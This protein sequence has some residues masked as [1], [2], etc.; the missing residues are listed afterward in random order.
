MFKKVSL[1]S[2][3]LI[4]IS[5]INWPDY[6]H[7]KPRGGRRVFVSLLRLFETSVTLRETASFNRTRAAGGP[8]R[9]P[10]GRAP[11]GGLPGP[12]ARQRGTARLYAAAVRSGAGPFLSD[13]SPSP[14]PAAPFTPNAEAPLHKTPALSGGPPEHTPGS[15]RVPHS[16]CAPLPRPTRSSAARSPAGP[17]TS[18]R[19]RRPKHP[20]GRRQPSY[21]RRRH[22]PTTARPLPA[23]RLTTGLYHCRGAGGA[24]DSAGTGGSSRGKPE[25]G[26]GLYHCDTNRGG[27]HRRQDGAGYTTAGG[28]ESAAAAAAARPGPHRPARPRAGGASGRGLRAPEPRGRCGG[29]PRWRAGRCGGPRQ[30]WVSGTSASRPSSSREARRRGGPTAPLRVR[31]PPSPPP[32]ATDAAPPATNLLLV[33]LLKVNARRRSPP[34]RRPPPPSVPLQQQQLFTTTKL[35]GLGSSGGAW[36]RPRRHAT[37]PLVFP[38]KEPERAFARGRRAEGGGGGGN[39]WINDRRRAPSLRLTRAGAAGARG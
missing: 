12:G 25:G 34:L 7:L 26:G 14:P 39:R 37:S 21:R 10:P 22:G 20:P 36:P 27:H 35:S 17:A 11:L 38:H 18:R 28:D 30:P 4:S 24:D 31:P 23:R 1:C 29:R 15:R 2:K 3:V 19:W 33:S 8:L 6:P 16:P 9:V 13:P 5:L 32:S